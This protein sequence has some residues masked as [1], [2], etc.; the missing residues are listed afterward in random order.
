MT[1]IQI[2]PSEI[3]IES[4]KENPQRIPQSKNRK[5]PQWGG[6]GFLNVT[7]EMEFKLFVFP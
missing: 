6:E 7:G 2:K 5:P 3:K 4:S 1:L